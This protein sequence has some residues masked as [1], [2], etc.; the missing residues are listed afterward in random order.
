[1]RPETR[2][3]IRMGDE[4]PLAPLVAEIRRLYRAKGYKSDRAFLAAC[5]DLKPDRLR[6]WCRPNIRTAEQGVL[7]K[8]ADKLEVPVVKLEQFAAGRRIGPSKDQD[9]DE[10]DAIYEDI[11][12]IRRKT[13]AQAVRLLITDEPSPAVKRGRR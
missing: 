5:D 8:M 12:P 7:Q 2:N 9:K 4:I 3:I 11:P 6:A 13:V 1:M 10:W